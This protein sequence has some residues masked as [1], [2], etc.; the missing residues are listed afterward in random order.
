MGKFKA[1]KGIK[2]IYLFKIESTI[3]STVWVAYPTVAY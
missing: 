3:E 1:L 2:H